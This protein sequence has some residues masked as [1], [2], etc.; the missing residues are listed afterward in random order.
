MGW[1]TGTFDRLKVVL[2]SKITYP[3]YIF[4]LDFETLFTKHS[5]NEILD[6]NFEKTLHL[7]YNYPIQWFVIITP[8][9]IQ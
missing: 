6:L 4:S 9:R 5:S 8:E 2:R 1:L 3:G 7:N